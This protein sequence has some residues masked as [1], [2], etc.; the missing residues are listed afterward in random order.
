MFN[1][2]KTNPLNKDQKSFKYFIELSYNGKNYFG[3]QI[4]PEV[5]SIQEEIQNALSI[6]L[7]SEIK[8]IG[9][10]RTDTG[11]HAKQ[12]FAHFK[13]ESII[14]FHLITNRLN[15][16]LS[17]EI[18]IKQIFLVKKDLHAR[19]SATKRS[20]EYHIYLGRNPFLL[21]TTWQIYNQTLDV[22]KMNE[23]AENLLN[24]TNFK[25]FSKSKTDVHTYDCKI[26]EAKWIQNDNHLTFHI[27]A[28]RFLRNMVRAI[29]GTLYEVGLNRISLEEFNNIILSQNRSNAGISVPARAL[30][31]TK[32][33]YSEKF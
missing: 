19:F 28:N 24:Y 27:T 7:K 29:V 21:D 12:M 23:A 26:Y 1:C 31:L 25:C 15:A 17:D 8:I 13:L 16:F 10:G 32:I 33:E 14:D 3:W 18:V 2:K 11:V 5:I 4:Q 20:Y 9:A 30:F 6:L 22:A